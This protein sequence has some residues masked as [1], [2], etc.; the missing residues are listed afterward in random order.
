MKGILSE[1]VSV[2]QN[3]SLWNNPW[4]A[5]QNVPLSW[6]TW[7]DSGIETINDLM[8]GNKL[9]SWTEKKFC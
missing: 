6:S 8:H 4:I 9:S 2:P 3:I 7:R 5:L 1:S